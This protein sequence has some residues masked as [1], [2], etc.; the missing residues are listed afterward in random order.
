MGG[1]VIT[2]AQALG[3]DSAQQARK[4]LSASS[5]RCTSRRTETLVQ[6]F[7][8][9]DRWV[10][11]TEQFQKN[12]GRHLFLVTREI[13]LCVR[14]GENSGEGCKAFFPVEERLGRALAGEQQTGMEPLA[15]A[16]G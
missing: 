12:P 8:A 9:I 15:F 16:V 7:V 6:F 10:L 4:K 14:E 13:S 2:S 3:L 5:R 1:E 11:F